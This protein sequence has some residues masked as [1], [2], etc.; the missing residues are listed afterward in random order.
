MENESALQRACRE[1]GGP[2]ALAR[3]LGEKRQTVSNWLARGEPPANK[4]VAVEA[5]S[6]VSRRELRSDWC[7]YWP[8]VPQGS[9]ASAAAIK[10]CAENSYVKQTAGNRRGMQSD[11]RTVQ[12][13]IGFP[14][15][16]GTKPDRRG[17]Q[18][19]EQGP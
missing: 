19:T 18:G 14:D 13:P 12:L 2:A 7:D 1:V 10:N 5:V 4:A 9:S 17:V 6:G 15:Q 16:R 11:R 8:D 3:L